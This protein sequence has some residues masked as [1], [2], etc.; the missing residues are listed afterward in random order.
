MH[1]LVTGG[2]GFIGSNFVRHL[3]R[4]RPAWS[5]TN[6]DK[7]TYSGNPANL[8]DVAGHPRYTFVHGDI[9]DPAQVAPLIEACD[10]VVNLAAE[11]H[12]DRAIHD[13]RPFV[14]TNVLGTQTLL[15]A[16][17]VAGGRRYVQVSTDEVYGALPLERRDLRFTEETPLHPNN[18]YA[19][20]KAAADHLVASYHHTYGLDTVIT[21]ASNNFGPCQFPEKL[22]PL[23]VTR[24]L[25]GHNVPLYGDGLH[26]RDW[27]H[28]EDHCAALLA[29]L[30]RG[31]RGTAY[32]IGADNEHSNLELTRALLAMLGRDERH[33]EHV[34][35]RPGHD[36]RCAIDATRLRN[37]LG[38]QP[39]RS[40]WPQALAATTAWYRAHETWWRPLLG[41]GR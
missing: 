35:D 21:R 38:W 19:A 30:E 29:V 7:L 25:D 31:R 16:V 10:A 33:I 4:E 5:V 18:P 17:R 24:L 36:R 6:L 26:V 28:V 41:R 37:E 40:A 39:M 20:S 3:L 12:V 22:I 8:A 9:A 2:C 13:P 11:S 34:P 23:F 32:N 15:D 14:V 1:V 27:I